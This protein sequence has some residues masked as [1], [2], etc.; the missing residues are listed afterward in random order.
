MFHQ[1]TPAIAEYQWVRERIRTEFPDIDEDTLADT[2]EGL[3]TLPDLLAAVMRAHLDDTDRATALRVRID[4][5]QQRLRRLDERAE[6]KRQL[7]LSAMEKARLTKLV[8]PDFTVSVRPTAPAL[9]IADESEIPAE[10]WRPQPPKLD[11]SR[12]L[13]ALRAG[14]QICGATLGNGSVTLAVRTK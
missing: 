13:S 2:A 7:V 3:T 10:Y 1:L 4:S 11:R 6:K 12:L 9:V 14:L 8:Q 5:M